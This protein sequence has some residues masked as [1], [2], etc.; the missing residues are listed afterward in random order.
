MVSMDAFESAHGQFTGTTQLL[1]WL[2]SALGIRYERAGPDPGG[3][4][5][6]LEAAGRELSTI[7]NVARVTVTTLRHA[8][9]TGVIVLPGTPS[10]YERA[11]LQCGQGPNHPV[12]M[13]CLPSLWSRRPHRADRGG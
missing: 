7:K 12:A 1:S 3:G 10:R 13:T 5:M 2:A 6:V 9:H 11:R 4:T 8:G